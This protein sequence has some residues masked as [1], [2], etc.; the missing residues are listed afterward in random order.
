MSGTPRQRKVPDIWFWNSY[1]QRYLAF[2]FSLNLAAS[3]EPLV[4]LPAV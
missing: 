3:S 1:L 2:T 4:A